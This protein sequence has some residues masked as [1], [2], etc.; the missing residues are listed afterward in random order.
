MQKI[1]KGGVEHRMLQQLQWLC[2]AFS[3][4]SIIGQL[5]NGLN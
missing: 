3:N 4:N 5:K 1:R 2:W